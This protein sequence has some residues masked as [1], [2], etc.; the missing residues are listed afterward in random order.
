MTDW[1]NRERVNYSERVTAFVELT[2]TLLDADG[3]PAAS[4]TVHEGGT[5]LVDPP[6][7]LAEQIGDDVFRLKDRAA[8]ALDAE[9]REMVEG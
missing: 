1:E 3:N 6:R 4:V 7:A 9:A 8:R 5:A 2:V